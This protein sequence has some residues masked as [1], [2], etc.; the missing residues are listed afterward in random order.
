MSNYCGN[1]RAHMLQLIEPDKSGRQDLAER[2]DPMDLSVI[3]DERDHGLFRR[4][5]AAIAK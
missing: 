5:S 3:V 1:S 4:A 2:R